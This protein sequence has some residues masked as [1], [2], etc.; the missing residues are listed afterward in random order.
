MDT[1][2]PIDAAPPKEI[3]LP[4]APLV[5]VIAQVRFPLVTSVQD[6]QFIGPFQEELRDSYPILRQEQTHKLVVGPEG[7]RA[8]AAQVVWRFSSGDGAW[9]VSLASDFVALETT[10][11]TSRNDF[12]ERF[13]AI[14]NAAREYVRPQFVD[15]LGVRYVDRIDATPNELVGLVR[16]EV[17]GVLGSDAAEHL[18]H[19]I[20]EAIYDVPSVG[21]ELKTRWG[22][23]PAGATVDPVLETVDVD[24]WILDL[25]MFRRAQTEFHPDAVLSDARAFAERIYTFFRWAVTDDFLRKYGGDV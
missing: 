11:Y 18:Q 8:T 7:V 21:A 1:Q 17:L 4:Q 24:S 12:L 14:V 25:D 16:P 19:A 2:S 23:V 10:S 6:P 13:L 22:R 3:P 5:R 15:R 20:T 9:R